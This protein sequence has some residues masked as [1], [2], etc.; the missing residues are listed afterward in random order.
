[1][2]GSKIKFNACLCFFQHTV[3]SGFVGDRNLIL[4][5]K[6]NVG[7]PMLD[8]VDRTAAYGLDGRPRRKSIDRIMYRKTMYGT[9]NF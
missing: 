3:I 5:E 7:G 8:I 1:M 6:S 4:Y 9:G 2:S